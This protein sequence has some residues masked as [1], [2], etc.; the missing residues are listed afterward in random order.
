MAKAVTAPPRGPRLP[1][2]PTRS[3]RREGLVEYFRGVWD[4]LRKVQWPTRDE[5]SRMTGIVIATVI[6]FAIIIGGA[7]YLLSLGVRQIYSGAANSTTN[8]TTS[9]RPSAAASSSA[10]AITVPS[11][12]ARTTPV[13]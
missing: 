8:T 11:A 2:A 1:T 5:L 6:L 4:E 3:A 12:S 7:D 9:P 13:P 10:P